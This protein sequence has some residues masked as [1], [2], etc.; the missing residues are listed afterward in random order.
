LARQPHR[1]ELRRRIARLYLELGRYEEARKTL[2]TLL[3]SAPN[4][5]ELHHLLAS[6]LEALG[7]YG[8]AADGYEKAIEQAP[9][10]VESYAALADLL[11]NLLDRPHQADQV[12]ERLVAHNN[13]TARAYLIR[14]R[15][16][17]ESGLLAEAERDINRARELAPDEA[18]V[19]LAAAEAAQARGKRD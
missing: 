17:T 7:M 18:D 8:E 13:R 4:D 2:E 12:L 14:A 1:D 5:G 3:Q 10:H 11:R 16:Q 19:L 15:F 9:S 6:C